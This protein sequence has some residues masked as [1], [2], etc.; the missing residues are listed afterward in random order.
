MDD[1]LSSPFKNLKSQGDIVETT[2]DA[3]IQTKIETYS[4]SILTDRN[5]ALAATVYRPKSAVRKAIMMAPAT[6]IKRQ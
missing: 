2:I 5:Q 1:T 6:G 4:L 3:G